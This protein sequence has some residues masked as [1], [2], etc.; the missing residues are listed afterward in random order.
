MDQHQQETRHAQCFAGIKPC[1]RQFDTQVDQWLET[2]TAGNQYKSAQRNTLIQSAQGK[3][4][5]W[6]QASHMTAQQGVRQPENQYGAN[7]RAGGTFS[8]VPVQSLSA[9]I[10][11]VVLLQRDTR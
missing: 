10:Q 3:F 8:G 5:P 6:H 7:Y 11:G 9:M 2:E 4:I 1:C